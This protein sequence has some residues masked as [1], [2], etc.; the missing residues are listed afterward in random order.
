[1]QM[2]YEITWTASKTD[3]GFVN[4]TIVCPHSE[5]VALQK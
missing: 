4:D 5:G 2:Y 1:M 3:T